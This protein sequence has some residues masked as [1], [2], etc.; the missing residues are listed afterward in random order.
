M[1]VDSILQ[2]SPAYNPEKEKVKK[3]EKKKNHPQPELQIK[4]ENLM[5]KHDKNGF[6]SANPIQSNKFYSKIEPD[7]NHLEEN[8]NPF[9]PSKND[10][11]PRSHLEMLGSSI[12]G[13]KDDGI[14]NLGEDMSGNDEGRSSYIQ[15]DSIHS[16][17][18]I[19][20][21]RGISITEKYMSS[22]GKVENGSEGKE[23]DR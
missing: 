22:E 6:I 4:Q 11:I 18:M 21:N 20:L 12:I 1:V 16:F 10:L 15:D 13:F 3:E 2:I 9:L 7:R 14:L 8:L 5:L 17:G 19:G 23:K